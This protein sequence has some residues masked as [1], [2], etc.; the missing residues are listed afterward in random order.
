MCSMDYGNI[1]RFEH[2]LFIYLVIPCH[3]S[4]KLIA[5]KKQPRDMYYGLGFFSNK[6]FTVTTLNN[7]IYIYIYNIYIYI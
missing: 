6:L 1:D 5:K 2:F 4:K 7:K 3:Y